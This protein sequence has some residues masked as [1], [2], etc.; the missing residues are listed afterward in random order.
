[1]PDN[2]RLDKWLWAARFFKTRSQA[3]E[4][5]QAGHV[6]LDGDALKPARDVRIGETLE[7]LTPGGK[8]IVAVLAVSDQRGAAA[9][10]RTLY[11]DLTPP[12]PPT[13]RVFR[14]AGT[15][16]PTKRDRRLLDRLVG[17]DG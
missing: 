10:A 1:M 16:R 9:I 6:K 15:G 5:C 8:K 13:P 2:V 14:D 3:A 4:A 7:V 17:E 11:N 12:E